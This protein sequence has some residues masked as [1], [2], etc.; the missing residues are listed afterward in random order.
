M[1]Q[2]NE[3]ECYKIKPT[4]ASTFPPNDKN[5]DLLPDNNNNVPIPITQ[6]NDTVEPTMLDPIEEEEDKKPQPPRISPR[7]K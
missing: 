4:N 1:V 5:Q 2:V 3:I 6:D 7:L